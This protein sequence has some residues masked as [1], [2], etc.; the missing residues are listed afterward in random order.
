MAESG[1]NFETPA[2]DE[3]HKD[4]D[5][6]DEEP[7]TSFADETPFQ[8]TLTNQYK[9]L[10]D[11]GDET[12]NEHR[13]K[14]LKMMVKQ[15]YER[16]KKPVRFEA[17]E[18]DWIIE[19]DGLSRPL[20]YI[21]SNGE[22]IPLSYYKSNKHGA[23]SQFCSFDTIQKEKGYGVKF[24][25]DVL[26]VTDYKSSATR[27]KA[28]KK[29][30]QDLIAARNQVNIAKEE[31][32]MKDLSKQTDVQKTVDATNTVETSLHTLMGL[33]E[34]KNARTQ[35]ERLNFRE[36][37]GL[38]EAL[39]RIRGE[40]TNNLAKLA[41]ITKENRKLQEA[42]DEI[43]RRYIRARLENLEDE[44]AAKLEAASAN[45]EALRSQ[46]NRLKET[47]DKVLKEDTTLCERLKT[48]FKEHGITI[49]SILTAIGMIIGVIVEAV[50]P[51]T[52][53][54]GTTLPKPPSKE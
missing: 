16:N 32:L 50:I 8:R 11:L 40:L 51:T 4:I 35:T 37:Q 33:P 38:D 49:V 22:D 43:S 19:E 34:V 18:V 17:D 26:G 27:I 13:L 3:D 9:A 2:F 10:N 48:L 45:K 5:E 29:E 53:G 14:L 42:E 30:F 28:G 25:R 15:F 31:I 21:E 47:I 36:L 12:Q 20:L 1:F 24:M 52:G 6:I 7:E 41:D 54:T 44:R 46:I 23:I 39:Q